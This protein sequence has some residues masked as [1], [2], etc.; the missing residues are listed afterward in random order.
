[1]V[2]T[3]KNPWTLKGKQIAIQKSVAEIYREYFAKGP[4][5]VAKHLPQRSAMREYGPAVSPESREILLGG[6]GAPTEEKVLPSVPIVVFPDT[7]LF[8][9]SALLSERLADVP[10]S[11]T[12]RRGQTSRARR[13]AGR[14]TRPGFARSEAA[15]RK[16]TSE[17][18]LQDGARA[19][20]T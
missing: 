19:C 3:T 13:I 18:R 6:S 14:T 11:V 16:A 15:W 20:A 7:G 10:W 5:W 1:M 9:T 12:R 4:R 8:S 17:R 2:Y